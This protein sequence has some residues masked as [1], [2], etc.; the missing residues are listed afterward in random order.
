MSTGVHRKIEYSVQCLDDGRW[1]WEAYSEGKAE[2]ARF[3]GCEISEDRAVAACRA[4][5]D[6]WLD[7]RG[8]LH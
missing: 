4:N 3:A 8:P 1:Q 2:G 6:G 7:G 5:I